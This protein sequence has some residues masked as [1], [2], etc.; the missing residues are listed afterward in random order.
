M[1]VWFRTATQRNGHR[2]RESWIPS[3]L[4]QR[5]KSEERHDSS[6]GLENRPELRSP[7]SIRLK[8]ERLVRC[9]AVF[10]GTSDGSH[11]GGYSTFLESGRGA[12][13]VAEHP[14]CVAPERYDLS[15]QHCQYPTRGMCPQRR[16][17]LESRAE[18]HLEW[19]AEVDGCVLTTTH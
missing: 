4:V 16:G 3:L 8:I 7:V 11:F 14:P 17:L 9:I 15:M 18:V 1:R 5:T 13:L 6:C 19:V 12:V 10:R 2:R